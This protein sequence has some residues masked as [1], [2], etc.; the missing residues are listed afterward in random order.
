[1]DEEGEKYIEPEGNPK[2][3]HTQKLLTDNIFTF[4]VENP[5]CIV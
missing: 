4:N 2:T 3:N 5:S 1:M